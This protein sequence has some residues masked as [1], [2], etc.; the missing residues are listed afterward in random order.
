MLVVRTVLELRAALE[1]RESDLIVGLVPTMGALHE[2]HLSLVKQARSEND[3]VV[4]SIFVN[5]TQFN[6]AADLDQYPRDEQ[7]DVQLAQKAGVD[8]VFAPSADE[9]YPQGFA[10]LVRVEGTVAETLEGAHRGSSHFD[11][12]AT[13]VAKLLLAVGA[14]NAYFGQ[15]DAQQLVVVRRMVADLCIA[16]RIVGC[17]TLRDADGLAM[18]SRN[19]RLTASERDRALAI[20]RSLAAA[21]AAV[22]RGER[23]AASLGGLVEGVL[24][25]RDVEVE[26]VAFVDPATLEAQQSIDAPVLCAIAARV[27]D[28]RLIDNTVLHPNAKE[29]DDAEDDDSAVARDEG[30]PRTDRDGHR[31]RLPERAGRG[32]RGGRH[33]ARR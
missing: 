6:D 23:D 11:G 29:A 14:D 15:K 27:G 18:S 7:R 1:E 13:I 12:M 22:A 21:E 19:T 32:A 26:Y 28:V 16:T 3:I 8:I 33:G 30:G 10:T 4:M 5:P 20:P 2:G 25:S 24:E 17:P 31:L 9:M